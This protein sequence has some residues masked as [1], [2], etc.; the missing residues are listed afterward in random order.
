MYFNFATLALLV[1]GV[2]TSALAGPTD[3]VGATSPQ[4]LAPG[5]GCVTNSQCCTTYCYN[6]QCT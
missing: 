4:C 5:E 3:T 6:H 1:L 2:C